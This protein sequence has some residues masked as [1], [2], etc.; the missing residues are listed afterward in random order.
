MTNKRFIALLLVR[1]LAHPGS[2]LWLRSSEVLFVKR[3]IEIAYHH[4]VPC[5]RTP[6]DQLRRIRIELVL[7]RVVVMRDTF[8]AAAFGRGH[9]FFEDISQLPVE[10]P[11]RHR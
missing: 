2:I 11:S 6:F 3:V 5:L 4:L 1:L 7:R 9:L 10:I 8:K